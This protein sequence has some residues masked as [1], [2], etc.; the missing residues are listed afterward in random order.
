MKFILSFCLCVLAFSKSLEDKNKELTRTNQVLLKT[1]REMAVGE[2]AYSGPHKDCSSFNVNCRGC[3]GYLDSCCSSKNCASGRVCKAGVWSYSCDNRKTETEVADSASCYNRCRQ[4]GSSFAECSDDCGYNTDAEQKVATWSWAEIYAD[5]SKEDSYDFR[6]GFGEEDM[7]KNPHWT[8]EE[9]FAGDNRDKFD[10]R[11]TIEDS[12][13]EKPMWI[14]NSEQQV[15]SKE[16]EVA[17]S[18]SC[19][20]RCRQRGSSFSECSEDCGYNKE[21]EQKV[22]WSWA[23]IYA[24]DSKEDSYDWRKDFGEED[25]DNKP[26]FSMRELLKDDYADEIDWRDTI[27][28][29]REERPSW[30]W[31]LEQKVA[32]KGS[33]VN[34]SARRQRD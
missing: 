1:L 18:A 25:M 20:N 5:E 34:G 26:S 4:R 19:Y 32:S 2:D 7:D 10:W 3:R 23:E 6:E 33:E 31:N 28:D 11:S 8:W 9:L 22:A 13:E 27:E 16:K 29:S 17:D 15:A 24:D 21:A 30:N 12:R 14:W